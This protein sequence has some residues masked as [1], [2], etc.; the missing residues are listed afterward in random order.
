M[1]IVVV[2][3]VVVVTVIAAKA[4]FCFLFYLNSIQIFVIQKKRHGIFLLFFFIYNINLCSTSMV[5]QYN[6]VIQ[7]VDDWDD[8]DGG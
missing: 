4:H 5:L 2:V 8:D 6:N 7:C 1:V 3:V